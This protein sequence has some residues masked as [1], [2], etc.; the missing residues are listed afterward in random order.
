MNH[1]SKKVLWYSI[2]L[3]LIAVII[4]LVPKIVFTK[5][6]PVVE[7][8]YPLA[9]AM[10]FIPEEATTTPAISTST[11]TITGY[12]AIESCHYAG[13]VMASGVPAYVGAVACPRKLALGTQV[14][15][16]G[17]LYTCEDRTALRYD[18]RYD[19]FF[20]YSQESYRKALV[21]GIQRLEVEVLK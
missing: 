19:I 11:A 9:S 5:E 18:G 2:I 8:S 10:H 15:I 4:F 20:G 6:K 7:M 1:K 16:K 17:S 21:F 14:R 3:V 13:C 12:S